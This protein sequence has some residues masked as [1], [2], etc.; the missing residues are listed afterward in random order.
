MKNTKLIILTAVLTGL[1]ALPTGCAVEEDPA[2]PSAATGQASL[3][4]SISDL[5]EESE[6]RA[7]KD[8]HDHW[9]VSTFSVGDVCG[10]YS[11]KGRQ[12]PTNPS[13]YSLRVWNDEMYFEGRNGDYYRFG[14]SDIVLDP[15]TVGSTSSN[16]YSMLY[17]PYYADMPD[18]D[19]LSTLPGI[20]LRQTDGGIEKCIDVMVSSGDRIPN[21]GGVMKPKMIHSFASIV[22]LR[23]EGF[24]NAPDKRIWVGMRNPVTDVRIKRKKSG[25]SLYEFQVVTQYIEPEGE[26]VMVRLLTD[27]D[28]KEQPP[29]DINKYRLFQAWPGENYGGR[30]ASYVVIPEDKV[31]FVLMQD[32]YEEWHVVTD[33]ELHKYHSTSF[34]R[35]PK[36]AL[37]GMR[38]VLTVSLEGVDVTLRPVF[39]TPWNEEEVITDNYKMGMSNYLEFN[40]WVETYNSY[41]DAGRPETEDYLTELTKYGVGKKIGDDYEWTF[42]INHDIEFNPNDFSRINR[43]E[44]TLEGTSTYTN[45]T[46]STFR[47]NLIE[48]IGEGG[49]IRALD[50][51]DLY[52]IQPEGQ[53]TPFGGITNAFAGGVIENCNIENAVVVGN[54]PVGMIAGAAD[55][56][57]LE[58]CVVSG[59][60]IG[61]S[62]QG[63]TS[64]AGTA[65]TGLF[66]MVEGAAPTVKDVK[67]KGLRFTPNN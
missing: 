52:I 65:V 26:D 15:G 42:F 22:F 19:D 56:G 20:P 23:G 30:D 55:G 4:L 31:A 37:S 58:A 66:G 44:D 27:K 28:G 47:T 35:T 60:A 7:T 32:N 38:Y 49:K 5:T 36:Q 39:V 59:D 11:L 41:V 1:A 62:S 45:Y 17:Y 16:H 53:D 14:N 33:F 61:A 12:N 63:V 13:D 43:L 46:L 57:T 8:S 24:E 2:S 64:T 29:F 18:P 48:T 21:T 25:N 50:F 3:L 67:T 34:D 10:M 51:D 9:S 6:T 40:K 54:G